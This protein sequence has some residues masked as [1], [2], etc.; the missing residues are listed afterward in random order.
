MREERGTG[1]AQEE[2]ASEMERS[3]VE[4]RSKLGQSKL[5]QATDKGGVDQRDRLLKS[6]NGGSFA[7]P[8]EK[9]LQLR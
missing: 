4:E 7:A 5:G 8:P 2:R 6:G 3:K 9:G 1:R